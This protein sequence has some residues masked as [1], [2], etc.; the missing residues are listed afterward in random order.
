MR[1]GNQKGPVSTVLPEEA[2]APLRALWAQWRQ[3]QCP[4]FDVFVGPAGHLTADQ[5]LALLRY[6][7][8]ARW[9]SGER[10]PA[11]VY[12]QRYRLLQED[13]EAGLLLVYSEFALRQ[14]LGETPALEEYFARFPHY[15]EGLQ[16]Q[17]A[18]NQ[19]LRAGMP[20]EL[21]TM[22]P[23]P[24][25]TEGVGEPAEPSGAAPFPAIPGYEIVVE[26][27]RGGMGVVYQAWQTDL[28]RL[29]ALKVLL[30]GANAGAQELARFRI[31]AEAVARL[32]HP[33]IVQIYEVGQHDRH[34][35]MALEY[36]EGGS[37]ATKL[38]GTPLAVRQAAHVVETL[39]R[40]MHYAHQ[41]GIVHRDLKPANILLTADGA[42]KITDFGLAKIVVGG[43]MQTQTGLILGTPSYMAP[44]Q[45][46]GKA[47]AVGPAA[48][49]YALGAILYE[50]LTGRPP[51]R[52]ETPLETLHQAQEDEPISPSR[53]QPKLPRD[54]ATVCLKCLQK[55]PGRRYPTAA[56]LA[57]DLRRFLAGEPITARPVGTLEHTWRWCLRNSV[58]AALSTCV[59]AL[60]LSVAIV[61]TVAAWRLSEERD[62]ARNSEQRAVSA[63]IG[64]REEQ[65]LTIQQ[66]DRAER[67][68]QEKTDK[69][70]RS[71]LDQARARRSSR[72]AGQRFTSLRKL[73]EAAAI[74]RSLKYDEDISAKSILELRN[75]AIDCMPLLDLRN[76]REWH[77]EAG[78]SCIAAFDA[79]L[80]RY[81]DS[82]RGGNIAVRLV[83]NDLKVLAL[84]DPE[85]HPEF[86]ACRFSPDSRFLAIN[87][88]MGKQGER[89]ALWDLQANKKVQVV[90]ARPALPEC[91]DFSPDSR[92]LATAAPG[93]TVDVYDCMLGKKVKSIGRDLRSLR[94]AFHPDGRKLAVSHAD[95]PVVQ[96]WDV[97]TAGVLATLPQ[98]GLTIAIAWHPDGRFLAAGGR[99]AKIYIWDITQRQQSAVLEGHQGPVVHLAF[100]HA[101]D[102]LTSS[103]DDGTSRLWDPRKAQ[104]LL[105]I[106]CRF[107]QISSDDRL[108]AFECRAQLG[109]GELANRGELRTLRRAALSL[110]FSPK[111]GLLATAGEDGVHLWDLFSAREVADLHLDHCETAAFHPKGQSLVT[112]GKASGLLLWPLRDVLQGHTPSW[113]LGPPQMLRRGLIHSWQRACWSADGRVLAVADNRNHTAFLLNPER[114]AARQVL[115]KFPNLATIALSPDGQW[116]AAGA[117]DASQL[118]IWHLPDAKHMR[119][120]RGYSC[121]AFSPN[122]RWLVTGGPDDYRFWQVGTW[123]PG[124]TLPR[125]QRVFGGLAPLSFSADGQLLALARSPHRVQ[126]VDPGTG[127][128]IATLSA[129]GTSSIS[130]LTFSPN[131]SRL[132]VANAHGEVHLW[133]LRAIRLQLADLGLDWNAAPYPPP[134]DV[135]PAHPV[136]IQVLPDANESWRSYWALR[137]RAHQVAGQAAEAAIDFTE[138]LQVLPT[139]APPRQ[140]AELL[141]MRARNYTRIQAYEAALADLQKAVELA[142]DFARA[143]HDLARL[144]VCG[145]VSL[146]NPLRAFPLAQQAV[147]LMPGERAYRHTLGV[148]YYRLGQY[149][150]A[151]EMLER[152][153]SEPKDVT[154]ASDLFCLAMC[155]AHRGDAAK[156]QDCYERAV[157]W[158]QEHQGKL[159]VEEK[160][161]LDA[162]RAEA[163]AILNH[164]AKP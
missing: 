66:R 23:P 45:A 113:Q 88:W 101:G 157:Q 47:K 32:Q 111:G 52:A 36:V 25:R 132:G 12:L 158:V 53:L 137:G 150:E 156:A 110:D 41:R 16:Q 80:E 76:L 134:E 99:D 50:M 68:E 151:V 107:H 122:S 71:Y 61:S 62:V 93:E 92:W 152:S 148:V 125:D 56:A 9:R 10:L 26:L 135:A 95:L 7:Q 28:H 115:G 39:A 44:E 40:T 69:L 124:L 79:K 42:V 106:P 17:H 51:F 67:A 30:A 27:G 75:E 64:L 104:H 78:F 63:E 57:E 1:E 4:D 162:L 160:K 130:S 138:A 77:R 72:E 65:N 142:P 112:Y 11:E 86:G 91:F 55:E 139:D 128:E 123:T 100:N 35:Y 85:P 136:S 60:L 126:L 89:I 163:E 73:G 87:Y 3:Q 43:E 58:L 164:P 81:A 96:I 70:W 19:A 118:T 155:H 120:L 59:A 38:V 133:D 33:H 103:S 46:A 54:V 6:D 108:V 34:P 98:P 161:E 121:A 114:P 37:L 74:L 159:Q 102:L 144:Y 18:L 149:V 22:V 153:L 127:R 82:D 84:P 109:I 8:Q 154:T 117:S 31:E 97:D 90:P 141:Q 24:V 83:T 147:H 20:S 131:G 15:R 129:P 145:P 29:V 13:A 105:T 119:D 2:S 21:P 49:V 146:R 116:A 48:D 5:A 94:I 140:R 143:C 14:E